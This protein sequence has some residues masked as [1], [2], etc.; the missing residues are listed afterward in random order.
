MPLLV[1]ELVTQIRLR[2]EREAEIREEAMH[3]LDGI[4]AEQRAI[5]ED[6][7]HILG[8]ATLTG[9]GEIQGPGCQST[10]ERL[11]KH[12][13]RYLTIEVADMAGLVRCSTDPRTIG[14]SI[15]EYENVSRALATGGFATGEYALAAGSREPVI[16]FGLPFDG[17]DGTRAGVMTALLDIHWLEIYLAKKPIPSD[18]TI[19]MTDRD[20][21]VMARVPPIPGIVGQPLPERYRFML[22]GDR[23]GTTEMT[24]FDDVPRIVA[25]SP[26]AT[27]PQSSVMMWATLAKGPSLRPIDDAMLRTL[28]VF[29]GLVLLT[30]IA[31]TWGIARFISLR[32]QAHTTAAE[33]AAVLASTTDGVVEVDSTWRITYLND[34][35]KAMFAGRGAAVGANIWEAFPSLAGTEA[36][37]QHR[38]SMEDRVAVECE[39]QDRQTGAWYFIRSFPSHHGIAIYFQDITARRESARTREHLT[40]ELQEERRRL[41]AVLHHM[42]AG[43]MVV[44]APSGR[45][46]LSSDATEGLL[47]H[48]VQRPEIFDAQAGYGAVHPEG[49]PY[50][51]EEY[52]L[53]RVLATGETIEQE[54]VLYRRGDGR[55]ITLAVNAMPVRN[56]SGR[57]VLAINSFIDISE[58][59]AMEQALRHSEER[60]TLAL[61]SAKAG[62]FEADL[63]DGK[64]IWSEQRYEILGID[65][66]GTPSSVDA[67]TGVLH[68]EDRNAVLTHR[69]DV[70]ARRQPYLNQEYR[71]LRPDGTIRWIEDSGRVFYGR[72]GKPLRIIGLGMDVTD[73]RELEDAFRRSRERLDLALASAQA[74]TF[75]VDLASD[76]VAWSDKTYELLGLDPEHVRPSIESWTGVIHPVDR[77]RVTA[78]WQEVRA[79]DQ[80]QFRAEYRIVHPDGGVRW[81]ASIGQVIHDEGGK[82]V[83]IAGLN[84]DVTDHK[85]ME[86]AL[87]ASEGRFRAF[88]EQ[89]PLLMWVNRPDGTLEFFN[90]AWREY[91]GRAPSEKARWEVIDPADQERIKEL[92][93]H[94]IATGQPYAFEMRVRRADGVYRRHF[95]RVQPARDGGRIVAW[96]GVAMD[97][98]DI[99]RGTPD[100]AE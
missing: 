13:P 84:R 34:R 37:R 46:L 61:A 68:P 36:E 22:D 89:A 73:R 4:A 78:L 26:V 10:L 47:G 93:S 14:V 97:I 24:G 92:R 59:K 80:P 2:E 54:E 79:G 39:A 82:P 71:I 33:M 85:Q 63:R 91:T 41:R 90:A 6:I 9:A 44:E 67:W 38:K 88:F 25:Y 66:N 17:T 76:R 7:E 75:D 35:A 23:R 49:T 62:L 55:L 15:G 72:D 40:R 43:L 32:E 29:T 12:V 60:L 69:A 77:E 95:G 5:I 50:R 52:P 45:L 87:R 31:G 70:I 28:G 56:E 74:G 51:P 94:A 86:E 48:P 19:V 64:S 99:Q 98:H 83:R 3:L 16:G 27:G 21:T 100:P 58:R 11:K 8:V 1:F 20:G 42:P 81:I 57:M 65:P 53:A 30:G 18:A 96:I